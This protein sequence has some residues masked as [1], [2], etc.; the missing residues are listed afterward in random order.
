MVIAAEVDGQDAGAL[1]VMSQGELHALAL[2]LFLP[3]ATMAQSPF[4][5]VVLDDPVQAMDPAKVNGLVQ[6]L[7][8]IAKTRQVIVFSHD[9]RFASAVR[10]APKGV[11]IEVLEVRREANSRVTPVVTHSPADRYL[12]DAFGLVKDDGPPDETRRR[13]LPGLLRMALEAQARE[14]FF[15]RAL[16]AGDTHEQVEATWDQ[17]T[18]TRGRLGLALDDPS[19]VDAWIDKANYRRW[20]LNNANAIHSK[21]GHG[22]LM[23]ACRN[24]EKT[25]TDIKNNAR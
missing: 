20:A 8:E 4:R 17:A 12:D 24:V 19:R 25:L 23:D 3:R 16:L 14:M 13:V 9:D 10:R 15:A 11:P 7:L 5:F 1:E 21:I 2:A 22:D 18:K 6:V